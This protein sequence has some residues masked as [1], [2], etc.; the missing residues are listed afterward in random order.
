MAQ[1]I[2]SLMRLRALSEHPPIVVADN[3]PPMKPVR[4]VGMLFPR[5]TLFEIAN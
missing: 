1:L 2:D 4:M 3:G 5:D